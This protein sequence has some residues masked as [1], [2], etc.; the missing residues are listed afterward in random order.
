MLK[1][2]SKNV[3]AKVKLWGGIESYTRLWFVFIEDS[4]GVSLNYVGTHTFPPC[5][6]GAN[7]QSGFLQAD[8]G[9][10]SLYNEGYLSKR[11][12]IFSP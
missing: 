4:K 9:F 12:K 2:H 8:N 1:T 5:E 11:N 7:R 10:P 6:T 3:Q